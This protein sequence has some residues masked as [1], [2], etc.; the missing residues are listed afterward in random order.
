MS[1]V[2]PKIRHIFPSY[3]FPPGWD[4]MGKAVKTEL[5]QWH[6]YNRCDVR[7]SWYFVFHD[8]IHD[9]WSLH[10]FNCEER[11]V[12]QITSCM[13][14]MVIC[15]GYIIL[16]QM[17]SLWIAKTCIFLSLQAITPTLN[18]YPNLLGISRYTNN[19]CHGTSYDISRSDVAAVVRLSD[20][21]SQI[22]EAITSAK[23]PLPASWL[24]HVRSW[25]RQRCL[26]V[27]KCRRSKM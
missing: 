8:Y 13:L 6:G 27:P 1:M 3:V 23:L 18:S 24:L 17:I 9:I 25:A 12:C 5:Y 21:A 11:M 14:N 16:Y 19:S 4:F 22:R 15:D 10:N 2:P 7:Y 26:I 20:S